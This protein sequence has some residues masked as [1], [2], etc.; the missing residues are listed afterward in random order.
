[1]SR[2]LGNIHSTGSW[3]QR[4]G[5]KCEA[6]WLMSTLILW[7]GLG[8]QRCMSCISIYHFSREGQLFTF[9][10]RRAWWSILSGRQ[11]IY[12]DLPSVW[13][14][15]RSWLFSTT[16]EVEIVWPVSLAQT[17]GTSSP[18]V[19]W[20]PDTRVYLLGSAKALGDGSGGR[21]LGH[22]KVLLKIFSFFLFSLLFFSF[23]CFICEIIIY[24]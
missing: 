13:K 24:L 16:E 9:K 8:K 5:W 22:R 19:C 2:Y 18:C 23:S 14:A 7:C 6:Q 20:R 21:P 11:K 4:R 15:K 10:S 3:N 1:M 12:N 17:L